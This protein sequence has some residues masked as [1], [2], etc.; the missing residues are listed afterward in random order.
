MKTGLQFLFFILLPITSFSQELQKKISIIGYTYESDSLKILPDITISVNRRIH[1][2]S[3]QRGKFTI[4]VG[5]TDTIDFTGIGYKKAT[6]NLSNASFDVDTLFLDIVMEQQAFEMMEARIVPYHSY[7]EL[8]TA[9]INMDPDPANSG[10]LSK[11]NMDLIM[12]Q[13]KVIEGPGLDAYGNYK[14]TIQ[15]LTHE[16][17]PLIILSTDPTKG[18]FALLNQLGIKM[19]WAK[20]K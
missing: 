13:N 1:F 9:I 3:D 8:K 19:P 6:L 10:H 15:R 18:I 20:N 12:Q 4:T 14:L 5:R 7:D 17:S 11:K 2:R 16:G